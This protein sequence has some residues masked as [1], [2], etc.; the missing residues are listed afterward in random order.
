MHVPSETTAVENVASKL[1]PWS[2]V[3]LRCLVEFILLHG[4]GEIWPAHK[5]IERFWTEAGRFVQ[6]LTGTMHLHSGITRRQGLCLMYYPQC[7]T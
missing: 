3:E 7:Y 2:D 4:T 1:P 6:T 5:D